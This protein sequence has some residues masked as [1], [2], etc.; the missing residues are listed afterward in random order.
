M[1]TAHEPS[2]PAPHTRA[3][4]PGGGGWRVTLWSDT[5]KGS[6]RTA[7]SSLMASGTA[8]SIEEWAGMSSA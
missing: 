4:P 7:C 8:K 2:A 5:A 6:A 1:A 3:R